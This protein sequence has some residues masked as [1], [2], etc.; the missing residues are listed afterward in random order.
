MM[1]KQALIVVIATLAGWIGKVLY[2]HLR[3]PKAEE[4][5]KGETEN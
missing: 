2:S 4:T 3:K 5:E 1:W